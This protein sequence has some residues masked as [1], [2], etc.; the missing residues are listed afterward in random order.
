MRLY[1]VMTLI[2]FIITLCLSDSAYAAQPL[3]SS[4]IQKVSSYDDDDFM[5][6]DYTVVA[7][8]ETDSATV[9]TSPDASSE[10]PR[11]NAG[12]LLSSFIVFGL[13]IGSVQLML[14]LQS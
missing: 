13:L 7:S 11:K 14:A 8:A 2:I 10:S 3:N 12:D 9:G 4:E 6:H 1:I 5:I